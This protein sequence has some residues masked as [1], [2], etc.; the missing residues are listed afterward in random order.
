MPNTE[1]FTFFTFPLLFPR[2]PHMLSLSYLEKQTK[3]HNKTTY[4]RPIS[5]PSLSHFTPSPVA[6]G[7]CGLAFQTDAE[8]ALLTPHC[9]VHALIASPHTA[10]VC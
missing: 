2:L 9:S 10:E 1:L 5:F 8:L 4:S 6:A 3:K 7:L